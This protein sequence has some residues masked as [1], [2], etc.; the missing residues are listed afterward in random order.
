MAGLSPAELLKETVGLGGFMDFYRFIHNFCAQSSG[1]GWTLA[2][3]VNNCLKIFFGGGE[4]EG[5]VSKGRGSI[6]GH[7][8]D[9]RLIEL[10]QC[11]CIVPCQNL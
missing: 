3:H 11:S 9:R 7:S 5:G 1:G 8:Y 4:V 6:L 10:A 2:V